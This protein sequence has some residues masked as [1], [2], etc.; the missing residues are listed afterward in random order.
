MFIVM[1]LSKVPTV[2]HISHTITGPLNNLRRYKMHQASRPDS[3][4]QQNEPKPG[5][6]K[7]VKNFSIYLEYWG[8]FMNET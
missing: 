1:E 3:E 7:D 2:S 6:L 5:T 4:Q 8:A